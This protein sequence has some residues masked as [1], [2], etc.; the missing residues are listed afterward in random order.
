MGSLNWLPSIKNAK[1]NP[2]IPEMLPVTPKLN[3]I[4]DLL[5]LFNVVKVNQL[6]QTW[7]KAAFLLAFAIIKHII[8]M[9]CIMA[10]TA[11]IHDRSS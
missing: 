5:K 9:C 8:A 10:Q 1:F 4:L 7:R 6:I 3:T 2:F 11:F